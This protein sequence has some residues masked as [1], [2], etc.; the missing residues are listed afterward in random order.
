MLL[1]VVL[2]LLALSPAAALYYNWFF[3]PV[4]PLA[5]T[6]VLRIVS[7]AKIRIYPVAEGALAAA[8]FGCAWLFFH[9]HEH[10]PLAR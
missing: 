5:L 1:G 10:L 2:G 4:A 9:R 6:A 8:L 7:T 3:I